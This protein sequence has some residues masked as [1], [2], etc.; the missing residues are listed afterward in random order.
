MDHKVA[1]ADGGTDDL[2]NLITACWACNRGKAG[3]RQSIVLHSLAVSDVLNGSAL[4]RYRQDAVLAML[5]EKPGMT[6]TEVGESCGITTQNAA[7]ALGRLRKAMKV[8]KTGR[9][10]FILTP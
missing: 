10:W 7:M 9:E 5:V 1:V 2:S 6:T 8:A 4:R 3:L